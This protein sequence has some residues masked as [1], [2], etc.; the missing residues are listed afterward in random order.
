MSR[1]KYQYLV[2][3]DASIIR[4]LMRVEYVWEEV[5]NPAEISRSL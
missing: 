4:L 3:E 5:A 2:L 1:M